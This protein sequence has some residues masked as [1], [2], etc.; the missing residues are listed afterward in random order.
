MS[1][2]IG[3][4]GGS[5]FYQ[6]EGLEEVED[7]AVE[8]PFGPP[9]DA[10]RLGTL[11]GRRVAFLARH[12]RGHRIPPSRLNVRANIYALKT[13]GVDAIL[14]VSA[15]GSL[16]EHIHPRS[17]V[18]PDQLFDHTKGRASTFFDEGL[19]AHVSFA[20]PF[21]PVLREV[22]VQVG[23]E[24]GETV[25][26]GG[27][28]ICIEGPQFS[29]RAESHCYRAWGM[30][31]IGMTAATEAK[32][33]REAEICYVTLAAVTDFDVW[34]PEHDQVTAE[35][36]IATLQQNVAAAQRIVRAV[37]RK[38]PETRSCS[39]REALRTALATHPDALSEAMKQR[40]WP[41]V[42]KY[43]SG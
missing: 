2:L 10:I 43:L 15:V 13:L 3:I 20:D 26:D 1:G 29:T 19:V 6:I 7:R 28:Y 11:E 17:F 16:R 24:A 23:R 39:C 8:T 5:G 9:S 22:L 34:H 42:G 31:V 36:V 33:A 18:V 25:H 41:L 32:L 30:D 4:I 12:G 38:F 14:S 40:L 21:C 37:L 27:T 35:M